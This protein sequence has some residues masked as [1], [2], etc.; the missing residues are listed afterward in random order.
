[1]QQVVSIYSWSAEKYSKK[2]NDQKLIA[3]D[4]IIPSP[5]WE[6]NKAVI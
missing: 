2:H 1:M 6:E 3:V 4:K 5:I